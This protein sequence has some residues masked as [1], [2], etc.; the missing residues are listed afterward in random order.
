MSGKRAFYLLVL[1]WALLPLTLCGAEKEP[2]EKGSW[3]VTLKTSGG[4]VGR[5]LGNI[6]VSSAGKLAILDPEGKKVVR[7]ETLPADKLAAVEKAVRAA[8]PEGWK[9]ATPPAPDAFGYDLELRTQAGEKGKETIKSV[10][11]NDASAA[12]I[13]KDL[14]NLA[15]A[16]K[17][18]L[19]G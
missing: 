1:A 8:K 9:S 13:P 14:K 7:E 12:E 5:G 10:S 15:A 16:L 4:L 3:S 17:P 2:A 6:R 19:K 11:W 18:L